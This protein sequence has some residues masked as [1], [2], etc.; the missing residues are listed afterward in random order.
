MMPIMMNMI[1]YNQDSDMGDDYSDPKRQK[2]PSFILDNPITCAPITC[3]IEK[4]VDTGINTLPIYTNSATS[5]TNL[6]SSQSKPSCSLVENLVGD[7][8]PKGVVVQESLVNK[9]LNEFRI[10]VNE[11][12][13]YF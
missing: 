1:D 12:P 7:G 6:A 3:I 10:A 11:M 13:D 9:E 4:S 5:S 2:V 8:I